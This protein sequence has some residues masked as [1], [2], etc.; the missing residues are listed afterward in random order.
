MIVVMKPEASRQDIENVENKLRQL[1]FKTHPIYGEVKTVIG[2]IG[3]RR[4]AEDNN[5][6]HL[7]GVEAIVPIMKPYK[8]VGR[9]LKKEK[10]IVEIGEVKIGGQKLVVMAGPCAVENE[11][12]MFEVAQKV[13]AAG[14]TILRGGAYK[15]RTSPY[16]FQGMEEDGLK[17]LAEVGRETGLKVVTEVVDTRDVELV[18]RYA[19][20]LQIGTRNMQN[21]RLLNEC[22]ISKKPVLLKRGLCATIEEWLMA[23]EYIA[24]AGNS[25]IILCERGIRTFETATRNTMDINAIPV[26]RELSHLPIVVDPSHGT[27]NWKWVDTISLAFVA[28]GVDGLIVEVHPDPANAASDGMQSLQPEKFAQM[29]EV[30]KPIARAVGRKI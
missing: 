23:A 22:G 10:T 2:A 1:G 11:K 18:C 29:M 20:I 8:L 19:D 25:N 21:Y 15:P 28:A 27:G 13:K 4:L 9:E 30:L 12:Q 17:L 26:V 6:V 5:L 7:P 24:S 3:D 14:A 16:S